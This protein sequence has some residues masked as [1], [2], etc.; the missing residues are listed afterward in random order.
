MSHQILIAPDWASAEAWLLERIAR[1]IR[2]DPL[3][4][5]RVVVPSLTLA[6]HLEDRLLASEAE[7]FFGRIFVTLGTLIRE[8][9]DDSR[10]PERPKTVPRAL[11]LWGVSRLVRDEIRDEEALA[12]IRDYPGFVAAA[13]ALIQ[14]L[15]ETGVE[16]EALQAV[17]R[18][19]RSR[20]LQELG[21][22][23]SGYRRML[24][25]NGWTDEALDL[26]QAAGALEP[27]VLPGRCDP[28]IVY[29]FAEASTAE[30]A[31]VRRL[32]EAHGEVCFVVPFD[33]SRREAFGSVEWV[34]ERLQAW[35]GATPERLLATEPSDTA[36]SAVR[37]GIF[38]S[39]QTSALPDGSLRLLSAS[40]PAQMVESIA[41][42]LRRLRRD[43]PDLRW[44]DCTVVFRSLSPYRRLIGEIFSRFGIP[45]DMP[46]GTPW[47]E[48]RVLTFVRDLLRLKSNG[49]EKGALIACLESAYCRPA[50]DARDLRRLSA[51]LPSHAPPA[52][53]SHHLH[54]LAAAMERQMEASGEEDEPPPTVRNRIAHLHLA[55][56]AAMGLE[57]VAALPDRATLGAFADAVEALVGSVVAVPELE[58]AEDLPPDA[59]LIARDRRALAEL[60]D[61]VRALDR[62]WPD[63]LPLEAF[64]DLLEL[65]LRDE[66]LRDSFTRT[67][68]VAV[69][70]PGAIRGLRFPVV[71]IAGL[72][73]KAFPLAARPGPF[74]TEEERG[75]VAEEVGE[76]VRFASHADRA[77]GERH[78]FLS[79]LEVAS[80]LVYL[81]YSDTEADGRTTPVSPFVDEVRARVRF[82]G[83]SD[84]RFVRSYTPRDVLPEETDDLWHVEEASAWALFEAY[85][86]DGGFGVTDANAAILAGILR[87]QPAVGGLLGELTRWYSR[88][89]TPYDGDLGDE[90]RAGGAVRAAWEGRPLSPTRLD[91]FGRCPWQFFASALLGLEAPE[92][93]EVEIS[94]M[95]RGRL[96]HRILERFYRSRWDARLGH[97][98]PLGEGEESEAWDEILR[99]AEMECA[100]FESEGI[101]GHPGAWLYEKQRLMRRL[102]WFVRSEIE[103]FAKNPGLAPVSLEFSFGMGAQGED[104]GSTG[105]PLTL[106]HDGV[107]IR[108]R[109]IVD[110]VDADPDG[111]S[112]VIDYKTG[113]S[114]PTLAQVKDGTSFQLFAYLLATERLMGMRPESG[115]YLMV[116][117]PPG[118]KGG[119][120]QSGK[121]V[122]EGKPARGQPVWPELHQYMLDHLSAY[123]SDIVAGRFPVL[124]ASADPQ[125]DSCRYCDYLGVCRI[126]EARMIE[127]K[128]ED[129]GRFA[130]VRARS[131]GHE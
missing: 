24:R 123:V 46:T 101:V 26:R 117:R 2:R 62:A 82:G 30:M 111:R 17:G 83:G 3:T 76:D 105:E 22:V 47:C 65:M 52:V 109:G 103:H 11:R 13:E 50:I 39:H 58:G 16:P 75:A 98:R 106:V 9:T 41:R 28:L 38:S 56:D 57:R 18:R 19:R 1:E 25:E 8:L 12:R 104:G 119:L 31:I 99:I 78:L 54:A 127:G 92:A 85:N 70:D 86:R 49:F 7:G 97:A 130:R 107:E 63:D 125:G 100:R 66:V 23:Y 128:R 55:G 37:A 60:V 89:I 96:H 90:A 87:G 15:Q 32:A 116:G 115:H 74:L 93:D 4:P 113:A 36:L 69:H 21:R 33:A 126:D 120:S 73:E 95:E 40:G 80:D 131:T 29:G 94:P 14:E 129:V 51:V 64:L 68:A 20:K 121:L 102:A 59:D 71:F 43:E 6:R 122:R 79:A 44:R 91:S 34:L 61:R 45:F 88:E 84:D 10:G 42:E 35:T 124:P 108:V 112:V 67:D 48:L 5:A 118:T 110:R 72:Q 27:S 81:V 114:A 53:I 77:A